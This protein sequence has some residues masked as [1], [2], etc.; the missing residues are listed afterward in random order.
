MVEKICFCV[1]LAQK[2]EMMEQP[3]PHLPKP[4]ENMPPDHL[5]FVPDRA[6]R[7]HY[8]LNPGSYEDYPLYTNGI[9]EAFRNSSTLYH[10]YHA[11]HGL[12]VWLIS[13]EVSYRIE[14]KNYLVLPRQPLFIPPGTEYYFETTKIAGYHKFVAFFQGVNLPSILE[15]L[16]LNHP[17]QLSLSQMDSLTRMLRLLRILIRRRPQGHIM[18]NG[19]VTMELLMILSDAIP[20]PQEK[21]L[22]LRL[23][24][25]KLSGN[26]EHPESI[27][28]IAWTLGMN[29]RTF[30]RL[31][32]TQMNQ[33]PHSYRMRCRMEA[34]CELLTQTGV[35]VKEIAFQLGFC[36]SFYF[37]NQFRRIHGVTPTQF[38]R[39]KRFPDR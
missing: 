29:E 11:R 32:R 1:T 26:F 22:F 35:S 37:C 31:F 8:F 18:R 21:S 19:G 24:C 7:T 13:G 15:T 12:L 23:A 30:S 28:S 14:K 27:A 25:E 2:G 16:K 34:A 36:N 10:S 20:R 38:R 6:M 4:S 5:L 9:E 3:I 17:I 33:S 39:R